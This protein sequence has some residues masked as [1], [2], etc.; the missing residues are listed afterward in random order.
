MPPRAIR[1]RHQEERYGGVDDAD[2]LLPEVASIIDDTSKPE[3]VARSSNNNSEPRPAIPVQASSNKKRHAS[4]T[5][6]Q[7]PNHEARPHKKRKLDRP[8]STQPSNP[9]ASSQTCQT[10]YRSVKTPKT[11]EEDA[12]SISSQGDPDSSDEGCFP[13]DITYGYLKPMGGG[14]VPISL[15]LPCKGQERLF[16]FVGRDPNFCQI[17]ISGSQV[18]AVHCA[19]VLEF[20]DNDEGPLVRRVLLQRLNLES[21]EALE[22]AIMVQGKVIN[23]GNE[24]LVLPRGCLVRFGRGPW[25]RYHKPQDLYEEA[26][27]MYGKDPGANSSVHRARRIHDGQPFVT[28]TITATHMHGNMARTELIAYMKLG[29]HSNIVRAM[30]NFYDPDTELYRIILEKATTDLHNLLLRLRP[31]GQA[32]LTTMAP[33]WIDQVTSGFQHVHE[34]GMAH[35]DVKPQNILVFVPEPG[36]IIMK[37]TDFGLARLPKQPVVKGPYL[38]YMAR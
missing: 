34:C 13:T 29:P 18:G 21:Q 24:P 15:G 36:R 6:Y 16:L 38:A 1:R 7:Q 33:I 20:I 25:Y 8:P 11:P 28:K 31:E 5:R 19:I 37:I 27:Q 17:L 2:D 30:E 14:A 23:L 4:D 10:K 9:R 35:R 32:D 12:A 26:D 22:T 3:P